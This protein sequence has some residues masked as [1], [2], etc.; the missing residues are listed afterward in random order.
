MTTP[1]DINQ[2][3]TP[4]LSSINFLEDSTATANLSVSSARLGSLSC[5][6][7]PVNYAPPLQNGACRGNRSLDLRDMNPILYH[8]SYTG[9]MARVLGF[10]PKNLVLETS[11]LAVEPTPACK[12]YSIVKYLTAKKNPLPLR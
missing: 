8:L 10:E 2:R 11:G 12:T 3:C 4:V 1:L 7:P 6:I 5:P 9:K